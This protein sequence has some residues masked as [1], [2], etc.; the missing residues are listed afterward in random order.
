L[1][2]YFFFQVLLFSFSSIKSFMRLLRQSG[3]ACFPV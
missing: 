1:R 3:Q 2:R